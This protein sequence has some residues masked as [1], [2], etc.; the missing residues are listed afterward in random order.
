L[1]EGLHR[2]SQECTNPLRVSKLHIAREKVQDSGNQGHKLMVLGL[3]SHDVRKNIARVLTVINAH[4]RHQLRLYYK[5]KKAKYLPLDLREKKTRAI[6]R[7]LTKEE[8]SQVTQKQKKKQTH[9]PIR[10]YAVKV[11]P[12]RG[13]TSRPTPH[14]LSRILKFLTDSVIGCGLS[15]EIE[16][17]TVFL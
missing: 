5:G 2:N 15:Y 13:N 8:A 14:S 11:R 1:P 17:S 10:K 16:V 12:T 9:F 4:Q 3:C 7:R 6:R